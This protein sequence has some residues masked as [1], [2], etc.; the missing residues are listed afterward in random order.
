M[1][2]AMFVSYAL[3]PIVTAPRMYG[4]STSGIETEPS[5]WRKFSTIAAHTRGTASA[6][7]FSVWAIS[8]PLLGLPS[9][10]LRR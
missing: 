8:V 7:P 4:W 9:T 5:D 6:E 3:G 2:W 10:G 1:L